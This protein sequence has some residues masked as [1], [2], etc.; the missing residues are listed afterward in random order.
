MSDAVGSQATELQE[1]AEWLKA[2][3]E[4]S[5]E[6]VRQKRSRNKKRSSAVRFL[7]LTLSAGATILLGLNISGF[8]ASFKSVAF[9][10]TALV[11]LISAVEPFFSFRALWLEHEEAIAR[12]HRL[13]D[14]LSFYLSGKGPGDLSMEVLNDFKDQYQNI[15]ED[16]SNAWIRE[17]REGTKSIDKYPWTH[18]EIEN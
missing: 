6:K 2:K 17:R 13:Q 18:E 8:E 4:L 12:L 14:G 11:T 5:L 3:V 16:L 10:F 15:W 1:K 9:T 7:A